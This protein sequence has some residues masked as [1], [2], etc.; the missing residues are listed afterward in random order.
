[1]LFLSEGYRRVPFGTQARVSDDQGRT[2][3]E[4]ISIFAEALTRREFSHR[5]PIGVQASF[6][7]GL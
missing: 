2:W 3:S 5:L 4:P 6:S 7:T 1:V